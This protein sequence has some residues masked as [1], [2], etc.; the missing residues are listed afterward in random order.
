MRSPGYLESLVRTAR[1]SPVTAAVHAV[2]RLDWGPTR[3]AVA[4][5]ATDAVEGPVPARPPAWRTASEPRPALAAPRRDP[6]GTAA[7]TPPAVAPPSTRHPSSPVPA[8]VTPVEDRAAVRTPT[9]RATHEVQ[10]PVKPPSVVPRPPAV[11][12]PA[13]LPADGSRDVGRVTPAAPPRVPAGTEAAFERLERLARRFSAPAPP[14][15]ARA[16]APPPRPNRP[17]AR[18]AGPASPAE[19]PPVAVSPM[20]PTPPREAESRRVEIGT[21]EVFVT[22]P[23]PPAPVPASVAASRAAASP[24]P[25]ERLSRPLHP[26]GIA[27]G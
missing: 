3:A 11:I 1:P 25:P 26:Y 24:A 10:A 9:A 20:P 13:V 17:D 18:R 7:A 2:R 22:Q 19:R 6:A 4:V 23:P 15:T 14:E 27:Q 8:V 5:D 12:R 16:A 21:I